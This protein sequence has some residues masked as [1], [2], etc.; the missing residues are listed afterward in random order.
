MTPHFQT[1]ATGEI[2]WAV[3]SGDVVNSARKIAERVKILTKDIF[4][5]TSLYGFV[6]LFTE[7]AIH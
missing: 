7:P 1:G 3:T 2:I 6:G 5:G 4:T